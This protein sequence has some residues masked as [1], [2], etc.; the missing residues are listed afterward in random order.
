[1]SSREFPD[2]AWHGDNLSRSFHSHPNP[3]KPHAFG[4][5]ARPHSFLARLGQDDRVLVAWLKL[6]FRN[7][8]NRLA[9][10]T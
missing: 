9:V 10:V 4:T 1:M 6:A 3:R 7:G 5:P 8:F 2:A